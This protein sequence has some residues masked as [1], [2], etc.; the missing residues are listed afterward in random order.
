MTPHHRRTASSIAIAPQRSRYGCRVARQLKPSCSRRRELARFDRSA[1]G[2]S[3]AARTC[4]VLLISASFTTAFLQPKPRHCVCCTSGFLAYRIEWT[5]HFRFSFRSRRLIAFRSADEI[6]SP[7]PY[8][9]S[10]STVAFHDGGRT[11]D[12][13]SRALHDAH[14]GD[15]NNARSPSPSV[16]D[17]PG[18]CRGS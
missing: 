5:L 6:R 17:R 1:S 3:H 10:V 15:I 4:A 11:T 18:S 14:N 13:G 16:T 12:F 9:I 2:V 8:H 7:L